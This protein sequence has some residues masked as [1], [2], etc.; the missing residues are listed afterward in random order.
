M[1]ISVGDLLKLDNPNIIDIRP[2]QS[3]NNNHIP[4]AKNIPYNK[5]LLNPSVYLDKNK[6]YYIYCRYGNTSK[7]LCL[8]LHNQG[9]D[10][11]NVLGGYEAFVLGS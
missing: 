9:Y 4:N 3:Y 6:K 5:L 8:I 2:V 7:S 11:C 1:N 10:V